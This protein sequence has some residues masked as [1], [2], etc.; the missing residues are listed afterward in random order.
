MKSD[1]SY[2]NEVVYNTF[3][4]PSPTE[5]QRKKI[6]ES[7][8]G[9]LDARGLYSSASFAGLYDDSLMPVE[10]RRAHE[11]NDRAVCRAYGWDEN[12]SEEDI[13]RELFGLYHELTGK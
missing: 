8:Q 10:L 13:V 6:E 3:A 2:S 5:S 7:A 1:Y 11:K 12:I 4:W 9:I